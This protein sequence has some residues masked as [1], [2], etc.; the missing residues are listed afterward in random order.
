MKYFLMSSLI[1]L[2]FTFISCSKAYILN[3]SGRIFVNDDPYK[4]E[5]LEFTN[6]TL[7]IY[8]QIFHCDISPQYKIKEIICNYKVLNDYIVLANIDIDSLA[9]SIFFLPKD[10]IK[11][12]DFI[13]N[14]IKEVMAKTKRCLG[15]STYSEKESLYGYINNIDNDTLYYHNNAIS[16]LKLI[17]TIDHESYLMNSIFVDK[18]NLESSKKRK[19]QFKR[20]KRKWNFKKVQMES[21]VWDF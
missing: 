13:Y 19:I 9:N 6:D 18:S 2:L 4:S 15:C 12:C 5:Y 17:Y 11:K 20:K 3:L 16:Y 1:M 14:E 21:T 8:T 7:C 10:E